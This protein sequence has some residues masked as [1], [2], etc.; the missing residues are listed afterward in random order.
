MGIV[1]ILID[2][3]TAQELPPILRHYHVRRR[4]IKDFMR[5]FLADQAAMNA[6]L[7]EPAPPARWVHMKATRRLPLP[8]DIPL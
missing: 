2:E 7:Y 1:P 3:Q 6:G 4:Q 8:K 5:L